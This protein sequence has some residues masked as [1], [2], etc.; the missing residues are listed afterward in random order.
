MTYYI[1]HHIH[2]HVYRTVI[3]YV[4]IFT[5]ITIKMAENKPIEK[6]INITISAFVMFSKLGPFDIS[7]FVN[8]ALISV[9]QTE[10]K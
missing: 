7:D 1:L 5:C 8:H 3:Y 9:V 10:S 6:I 2:F 4:I